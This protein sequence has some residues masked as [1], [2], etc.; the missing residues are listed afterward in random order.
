VDQ[1]IEGRF[2]GKAKYFSGKVVKVR[3]ELIELR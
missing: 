3:Q 2:E 1:L